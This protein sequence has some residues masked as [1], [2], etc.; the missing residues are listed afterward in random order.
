MNP[1]TM[2]KLS[3]HLLREAGSEFGN[4]G[5]NDMDLTELGLSHEE[6]VE[7]VTKMHKWNGDPEETPDAIKALPH[8]S[9][10][11]VMYA[12]ARWLDEVAE[13]SD[14]SGSAGDR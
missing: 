6:Q 4:H 12:C 3:A 9:D 11:C 2:A 7:L 13:R 5:C 1:A 10:F 14:P 8:T